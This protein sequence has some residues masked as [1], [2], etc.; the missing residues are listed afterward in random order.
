[1]ARSLYL[2]EQGAT[3]SRRGER[4]VVEHEGET[5]VDLPAAKVLRVFV[6]GNVS[7]TTPAIA[8]LLREGKEVAF[9]SSRGRYY[10]RLISS[11]SKNPMLRRA[12]LRATDDERTRLGLSR[13][14]VLAKLRNQRR[15]LHRRP[16]GKASLAAAEITALI[17]KAENTGSL[18]ALRGMEGLAARAYFRA[19]GELLDSM[20]FTGRQRR[21]PPDPVNSLLSLGYTLLTYEAFSAVASVGFDPYIGFFHTDTYGRPSLAL[22]IMEELRPVVVDTL[23]LGVLNRGQIR[24]EDFELGEEDGRPIALLEDAA[25][26]RFLALYEQ[27][28]LT[29]ITHLDRSMSYRGA[30]HAQA[31]QVVN[32]IKN[33]ERG[34]VPVLLK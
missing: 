14:L 1:M 7:L 18:P 3:L 24:K 28:M 8:Y 20:P 4:L 22:D 23:V 2:T 26:K 13:H 12:Q 29:Q 10:G 30:V 27:R 5:L 21:P 31:R 16:G 15:I 17:E 9:L 32:Y 25:R 11:E 6:F 19:F 34:Y 33:P